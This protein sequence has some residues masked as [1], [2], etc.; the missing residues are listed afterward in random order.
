MTDVEAGPNRERVQHAERVLVTGASGFVGSALAAEL[1]A[2]FRV[3]AA[4]RRAPVAA[5]AVVVGDLGPQTDWRRALDGV[6]AVVHLAGPAHSRFTR[7]ELH[8]AIVV[9]TASLLDHAAKAGVRRFVFVSSIHACAKQT[10]GAPLTE[11]TPPDPSDDYGRA[12]LE[13]E[14]VA[15]GHTALAPVVLRPPLIHDVRAKANFARLLRLL[16]SALPVPLGGIRNKRSIV[17]LASF[18]AAVA[19]VLRA[20]A[21]AGLFHVCDEPAVSTTEMAALLRQGMGRRAR[22]FA[23]PG[24]NAVAPAALHE[25]L[26]IDGSLFRAAFGY[27]GVETREALIACGRQWASQR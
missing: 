17:S 27:A 21:T 22:L 16:D 18:N 5:D 1:A 9:G 13:A 14:R 2:S 4:Y 10:R 25:S 26:E 24:L 20:P 12:K 15:L 6:D 23:L 19:A 7:E 3:R 11:A 8:G